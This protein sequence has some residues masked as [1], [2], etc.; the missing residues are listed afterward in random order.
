MSNRSLEHDINLVL[1]LKSQA[2]IKRDRQFFADFIESDFR[3]VTASGFEADKSAYIDG[4]CG[5]DG[6][7]FESQLASAA[8]IV[9]RGDLAVVTCNLDDVFTSRGIRHA[10]SLKTLLVLVRRDGSWRWLAGQTM[11]PRAA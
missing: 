8:H 1:N 3:Y 2:L 7:Q 6:L 4:V 9:V 11:E 10:K 5:R